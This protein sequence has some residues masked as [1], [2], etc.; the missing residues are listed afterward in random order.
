MALSSMQVRS[1]FEMMA[2]SVNNNRH[3]HRFSN[4]L[5]MAIFWERTYF[6]NIESASAA[7]GF[8]VG[9]GQLD[10]SAIRPANW[11]HTGDFPND[12]TPYSR[13]TILQDDRLAVAATPD[14][15]E[16]I[17]RMNEHKSL[18]TTLDVYAGEGNK[19]LPP[20]WR[21]CE[22]ELKAVLQGFQFDPLKWDP[23]KIEAALR[24]ARPF[25]SSG[26]DYYHFHDQLFPF[27]AILGMLVHGSGYVAQGA[28]GR[29]VWGIQE[30][31]NQAAHRQPGST[32]QPMLAVDGIFG[33]RTSDRVR[34]FQCRNR[35]A[36]DGVV[37]PQTREKL[38]QLA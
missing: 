16:G 12:T 24:R 37:G 18:A 33:P 22:T 6:Q 8:K 14:S 19:H 38:L 2:L 4:E 26:P 36:P 34:E 17:A 11:L 5:V 21:A 13:G 10:Q 29:A 3:S 1:F 23:L 20:R 9:F 35:I 30:L 27:Q 15:L 31:M 7:G 28:V 32:V 25:P